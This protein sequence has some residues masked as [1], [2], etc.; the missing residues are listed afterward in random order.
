MAESER[1][2]HGGEAE[3]TAS[4][5]RALLGLSESIAQRRDMASLVRDLASH[6]REVVEFDGIAILLH[7]AQDGKM[8]VLVVEAVG[9]RPVS[10]PDE[11]PAEGTPGRWVWQTQQPLVIHNTALEVRFP[12]VTR[13]MYENGVLSCCMLPLTSAGRRLG[14]L[15][16]GSAKEAAYGEANLE[17][18]LQV[19]NQ[20]AVAV[21]NALNFESAQ[22]AQQQLARERDRFRLLLEVNNAVTAH[23]DLRKVFAAIS[24]SLRRVM[25]F[26]GAGLTLYYPETGQLRA[27]ALETKQGGEM[28][29]PIEEGELSLSYAALSNSLPDIASTMLAARPVGQPSSWN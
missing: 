14:A 8:R 9:D 18:M 22:A 7:Y 15:G 4:Q 19:A 11:L 28:K 6:L 23:L 1:A 17:F 3:P 12:Q 16:F 29:S 5:Y 20:V 27:V 25:N 21:D 10:L 24:A 26:D 2:Q 13:I